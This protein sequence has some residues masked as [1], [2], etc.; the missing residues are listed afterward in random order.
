MADGGA[1]F[2]AGVENR[3]GRVEV[4][5]EHLQRDFTDF[6]SE[7]RGEMRDMRGEMRDLRGEMRDTR[8]RL[9]R[10]EE[11]VAHLPTKGWSFTIAV[12]TVTAMAALI[13]IAPLLQGWLGLAPP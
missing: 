9:I 2:A 12:L 8:E 7:V 1:S 6:R 13:T 5:V 11:R 3:L 10:L 4:A